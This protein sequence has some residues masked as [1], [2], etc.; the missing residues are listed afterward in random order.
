MGSKPNRPGPERWEEEVLA[1]DEWAGSGE[2]LLS[3]R[4]AALYI[5][6]RSCPR[7]ADAPVAPVWLK[8]R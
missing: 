6:A 8:S 1:A 2:E 7:D 5:R 3:D 4:P